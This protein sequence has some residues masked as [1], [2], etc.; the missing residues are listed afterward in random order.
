MS[1]PDGSGWDEDGGTSN[2]FLAETNLSG[3]LALNPGDATISLGN[4]FNLATTLANRD[5]RFFIHL[6]SG[7]LIRGN[8]NYSSSSPGGGS[9]VPEPSSWALLLL[10]APAL[11]RRL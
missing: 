2:N 3:P 7:G 11:R 9:G 4:I 5:V 10:A 8:V 1:A 6:T